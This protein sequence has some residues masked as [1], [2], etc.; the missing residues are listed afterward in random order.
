MKSVNS[1]DSIPYDFE[2]KDYNFKLHGLKKKY[3][4]ETIPEYL[5]NQTKIIYKV[6]WILRKKKQEEQRAKS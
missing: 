6:G 3:L 4:S 1:D 5:F 2:E